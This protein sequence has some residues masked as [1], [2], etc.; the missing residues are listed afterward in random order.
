MSG[1]LFWLNGPIHW[2][3][4]RQSITARSSAEA[5]IYATDECVKGLLHLSFLVDGLNLSKLIMPRPINVYND[6]AACVQWAVNLTSKGL[7]HI[8][9]RENAVRESVQNKFVTIKHIKGQVNLSDLFTK[10]DKDVGHFIAIRNLLVSGP[11][12]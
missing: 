1:F 11:P 3:S 4:K 8:Q 12:Q 9:M 6:N 2:M 7:R 10:E 5:E